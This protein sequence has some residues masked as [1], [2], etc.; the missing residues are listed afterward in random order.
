M[1]PCSTCM[2]SRSVWTCIYIG[3]DKP[4]ATG[5]SGQLS[6]QVQGVSHPPQ[7]EQKSFEM[8]KP[9]SD[10]GGSLL[11]GAHQS[12]FCK[13][14]GSFW[15]LQWAFSS[16][17]GSFWGPM[18]KDELVH[19]GLQR[20]PS[21]YGN[22]LT[23]QRPML[24]FSVWCPPRYVLQSLSETS[25][26]E[27]GGFLGPCFLFSSTSKRTRVFSAMCSWLMTQFFLPRSIA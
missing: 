3:L 19:W 1:S 8:G 2:D 5:R 25:D 17:R 18:I 12:Q 14:I 20:S 9:T 10:L 13:F 21:M 11:E 26:K 23:W 24:I 15:D 22:S 7:L 6:V 27:Q 16:I 4:I